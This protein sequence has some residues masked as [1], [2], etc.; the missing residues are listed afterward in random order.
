MAKSCACLPNVPQQALCAWCPT[1]RSR[2][3]WTFVLFDIFKS[4]WTRHCAQACDEVYKKKWKQP[5]RLNEWLQVILE[6][7]AWRSPCLRWT[8][9]LPG[10]TCRCSTRWTALCSDYLPTDIGRCGWRPTPVL[11]TQCRYCIK[12]CARAL[13]RWRKSF[14]YFLYARFVLDDQHVFQV[15]LFARRELVDEMRAAGVQHHFERV[16]R[17]SGTRVHVSALR[18]V[19]ESLGTTGDDGRRLNTCFYHDIQP[20]DDGHDAV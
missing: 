12:T 19:V 7:R 13:Q 3:Q 4:Q 6:C 10:S 9:P 14:A 1:K 5:R 16:F 18:T 8:S 20:R 17:L 11:C 15:R 2:T